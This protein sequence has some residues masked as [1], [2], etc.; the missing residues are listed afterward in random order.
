M[1]TGRALHT[2]TLLTNGQLL[3]AG[4]DGQGAGTTAELYDSTGATATVTGSLNTSRYDHTA[5]LLTNGKVLIAGGQ[6]GTTI[7]SSAELYIY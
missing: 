2:A 5:T 7:W 3:I 4:G 1:A 6:D